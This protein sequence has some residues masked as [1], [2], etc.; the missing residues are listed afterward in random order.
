MAGQKNQAALLRRALPSVTIHDFAEDYGLTVGDVGEF[1]KTAQLTCHVLLHDV[2]GEIPKPAKHYGSMPGMYRSGPRTYQPPPEQVPLDGYYQLPVRWAV[3][4]LRE[5]RQQCPWVVAPSADDP[6]R[7]VHAA[8]VT[9]W[10]RDLRILREE[11][12]RF[13][14]EVLPAAPQPEGSP[15]IRQRDLPRYHPG[16][17]RSGALSRRRR[18]GRGA[19]AHGR[20]AGLSRHRR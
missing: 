16:P 4:A 6:D 2:I 13:E 1:I 3:A 9:L 14:R 8:G 11:V 7:L 10:P 20:V 5:A 18:L 19:A 15:A 17:A 12:E